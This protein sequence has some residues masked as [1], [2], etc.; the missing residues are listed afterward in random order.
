MYHSRIH[1]LTLV[2]ET[3]MGRDWMERFDYTPNGIN[4]QDFAAIMSVHTHYHGSGN[5]ANLPYVVLAYSLEMRVM[6]GCTGFEVPGYLIL[7]DAT[8]P[9][10]AAEY[11]ILKI[12]VD[13]RPGG[14]LLVQQVESI[15]FGWHQSLALAYEEVR[16]I[17]RGDFQPDP[18]STTW[19]PYTVQIDTPEQHKLRDCPFCS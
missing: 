14:A 4:S 3:T 9:D 5:T 15:T 2:N 6:C 11:G 19:Q 13:D 17:L 1:S 18:E 16:A 8:S 7:N 10:G 12:L